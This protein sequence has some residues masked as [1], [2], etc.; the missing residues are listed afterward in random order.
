MRGILPCCGP[1]QNQIQ[2]LIISS[3]PRP[4]PP[5]HRLHRLYRKPHPPPPLI[6][7]ASP[8]PPMGSP[9]KAEE[10]TNHGKEKNEMEAKEKGE[11]APAAE[12]SPSPPLQP[13]EKPLPGDCCGSGCVRCVWDIYYEELDAYNKALSSQSTEPKPNN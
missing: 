8:P 2:S 7:A 12:S 1:A 5:P 13:P 4:S 3:V 9:R 11:T 10:E 6:A